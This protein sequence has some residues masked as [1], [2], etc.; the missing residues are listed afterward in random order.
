MGCIVAVL[1]VHMLNFSFLQICSRWGSIKFLIPIVH[2][3]N[4]QAEQVADMKFCVASSLE[5]LIMVFNLGS[6]VAKN[7]RSILV[8]IFLICLARF[9]RC[10]ACTAACR[11]HRCRTTQY[12]HFAL[13]LWLPCTPTPLLAIQ[14]DGI[15]NTMFFD[16]CLLS[17]CPPKF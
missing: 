9:N 14:P 2:L 15:I 6:L 7:R 5:Q 11:R 8:A 3:L 10:T 17:S 1:S 4:L 16:A 12:V 13:H